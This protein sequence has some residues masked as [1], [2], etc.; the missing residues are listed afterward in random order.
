MHSFFMQIFRQVPYKLRKAFAGFVQLG[1][2]TQSLVVGGERHG[3]RLLHLK[4]VHRHLRKDTVEA[5]S[6]SL[7]ERMSE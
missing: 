7:T 6:D 4:P 2:L 3:L 5:E 1:T